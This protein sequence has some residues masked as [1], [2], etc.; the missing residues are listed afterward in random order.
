MN[1]LRLFKALTARVC[2]EHLE[3]S[4]WSAPSLKIIHKVMCGQYLSYTRYSSTDFF[5]DQVKS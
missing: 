1:L 4:V 3:I 5:Q 2:E